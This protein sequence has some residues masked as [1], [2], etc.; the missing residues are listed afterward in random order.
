MLK[1]YWGHCAP[2]AAFHPV[3]SLN[4]TATPDEFGVTETCEIG[5][6]IVDP[7]VDIHGDLERKQICSL[8]RRFVLSLSRNLQCI[9]VRHYVFGHK[10]SKI[11]DDLGVSRSAVCHALKRVNRLGL[12]YL[13][14]KLN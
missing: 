3:S 14:P 8:V 11:A 10:Q 6:L 1:D 9:V 5:D 12:R 4:E 13:E 2:D 7:S